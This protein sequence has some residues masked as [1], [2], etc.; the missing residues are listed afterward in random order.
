M[1]Y[2]SFCEFLSQQYWR[3]SAHIPNSQFQVSSLETQVATPFG[4]GSCPTTRSKGLPSAADATASISATPSTT[5]KTK[6]KTKTKSAKSAKATKPLPGKGSKAKDSK[7][8]TKKQ[9]RKPRIVAADSVE[10]LAGHGKLSLLQHSSTQTCYLLL[11]SR[12]FSE[13]Q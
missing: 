12:T 8:E 13:Q 10:A 11:T 3:S 4:Q 2:R 6:T 9:G 7:T 5:A 1:A